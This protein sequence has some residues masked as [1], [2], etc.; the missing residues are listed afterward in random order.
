MIT[1]HINYLDID[2]SQTVTHAIRKRVLKLERFYKR[3][4]R[5]DVTVSR[6]DRS[7]LF[8]VHIRLQVPGNDIVISHDPQ[9]LAHIDIM[10][11]VRDAFNAAERVLQ[12]KIRIMRG[13]TKRTEGDM[14]VTFHS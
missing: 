8:Q 7:R 13:D 12:D 14:N 11:A 10:V 1:F 2:E 9:D 4:Q 3:I 5:C 6:P